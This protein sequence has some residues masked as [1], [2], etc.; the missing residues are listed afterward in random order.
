[1]KRFITS[2][3]HG[4]KRPEGSVGSLRDQEPCSSSGSPHLFACCFCG[5]PFCLTGAERSVLVGAEGGEQG[6]Q[7]FSK[8][9][10]GRGGRTDSSSSSSA[11][12]SSSSS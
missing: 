2:L 4:K 6:V 5:M 3:C 12:S 1:M 11:V 8:G 10:R 7:G 9:R